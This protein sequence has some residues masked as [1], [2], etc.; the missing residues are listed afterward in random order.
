[1]DILYCRYGCCKLET[2]QYTGHQFFSGK[3]RRKAGVFIYDPATESILL[4]QSRGNLWGVPKGSIDYGET[5]RVCAVREVKEETGL[6]VKPEQFSGMAKMKNKA[7]YFYLEMPK[8]EVTVQDHVDDN[9]ANGIGWVKLDC[10]EDFLK[11]DAVSVN[12]H[13]RAMCQKFLGKELP[14]DRFQL[15]DNKRN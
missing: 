7:I 9:D 4:V 11:T 6:E 1:M 10:L 5:E 14:E 12:K 13:C 2:K 15:V 8:C 3:R